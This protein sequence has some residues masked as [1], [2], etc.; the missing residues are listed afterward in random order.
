MLCDRSTNHGTFASIPISG[1]LMIDPQSRDTGPSDGLP[2]DWPHPLN[3]T[4]PHT[5]A[6]SRVTM[7]VMLGVHEA[8]E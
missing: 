6:P 4:S 5:A 7:S 3:S 8:Q 1:P 2:L